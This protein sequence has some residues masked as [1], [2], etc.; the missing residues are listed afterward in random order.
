MPLEKHRKLELIQRQLGLKH[1]IKVHDSMK[2]P[3]NHEDIAHSLVAKWEFEDELRAVEEI[4]NED[5]LQNVGQKRK[6]LLKEVGVSGASG[7]G[8]SSSASGSATPKKKSK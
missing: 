3:D 4:L 8:T 2:L 7:D 6:S 1:K 5:R